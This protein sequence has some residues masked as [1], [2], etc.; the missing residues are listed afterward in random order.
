MYVKKAKQNCNTCI[1]HT[2]RL[3]MF[4]HNAVR[5]LEIPVYYV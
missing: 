2:T 3:G 4:R 1:I 5:V